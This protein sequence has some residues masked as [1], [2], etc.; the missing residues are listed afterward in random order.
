MYLGVTGDAVAGAHTLKPGLNVGIGTTVPNALLQVNGTTFINATAQDASVTSAKLVVMQTPATADWTQ[1]VKGGTTAGSSYGIRLNAGT[2]SSD[3]A[4]VV[5]DVTNTNDFFKIRGDGNVGIGTITPG[6][7][8]SVVGTIES[9]S[10]GFEFPDG[11]TQTT[12]NILQTNTTNA[13]SVTSSC[14]PSTN[15]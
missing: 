2:N 15:K 8:L 7:R 11:T 10:G 13:G 4:L 9:T 5:R 12:S 3:A 6:Q 1:T 14:L